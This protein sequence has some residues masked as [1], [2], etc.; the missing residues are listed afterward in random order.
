MNESCLTPKKDKPQFFYTAEMIKQTDDL[1]FVTAEEKERLSNP[2]SGGGVGPVGP[3]GPKGDKGDKGD[4]GEQG[5]QGEPGRD[6]RDGVDGKVGPQ[7]EQGPQGPKGEPGK[8]GAQG[9]KGDKG[10]KGEQGPPGPQGPPGVGGG[11]GIIRYAPEGANNDCFVTATGE[12][13]T[14][15]KS[16]QN[17][18]FTVPEGVMLTSVQ[19]KFTAQ[20]M[21]STACNINYGMG[22]SYDDLY[23]PIFQVC[24]LNDGSKP[25]SK[26]AAGNLTTSPS[27][28]QLSGLTASQPTMIKLIFA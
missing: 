8:D 17:A 16:G 25:Y 23:M 14:F 10:E 9:P 2:S 4:P 22:G 24:T 6:G 3:Q 27:T 19:V 11:V 28:I 1:F 15:S 26:A 12:G 7:G 21:T 13:V 18:T 20:E 5:P